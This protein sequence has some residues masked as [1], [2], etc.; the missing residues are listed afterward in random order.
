MATLN[1]KVQDLIEFIKNNN[2]NDEKQIP[3]I[4]VVQTQN[5]SKNYSEWVK[6][7]LT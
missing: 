3:D 5:S 2:P 1:D 4:F 6:Q 7:Q